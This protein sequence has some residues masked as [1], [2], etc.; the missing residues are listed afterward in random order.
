L[1]LTKIRKT[2]QERSGKMGNGN[3]YDR[4]FEEL[5][6]T[7]KVHPDTRIG[8]GV[9]IGDSVVDAGCV[10]CD[11]VFIGHNCV[12][13]NNVYIGDDSVIGHNVVIEADTVIGRGTTIQSQCHITKNAIIG[14]NCF[15]G[16]T[17]VMI[18]THRISHGRGFEPELK[19]PEIGD[20]CRIGTGAL[21]M[22]GV[23][24]G[25]NSVIGAG[26][27]LTKDVGAGEIWHNRD[28]AA[29]RGKVDESEW[30]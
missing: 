6:V 11:R 21:I 20:A 22:P 1:P 23:K 13:R 25:R 10:I 30:L 19:G 27:L 29:I 12:I 14:N 3:I 2:N 7:A 4:G 5:P 18:N 26:S 24:V 8:S 17:A 15:F 9:K 16:P 28:T